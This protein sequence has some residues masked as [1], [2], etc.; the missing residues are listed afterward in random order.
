MKINRDRL[1]QIIKE[2]ISN[3]DP[4]EFPDPLPGSA[5]KSF[6][7]KGWDDTPDDGQVDDR[8]KDDMVSVELDASIPTLKLMPSQ[9]AIFLGKAL[10][11]SMVPKLSQGGQ[12]GGVISEDNHILDGHHRWAAT[13]LRTGGK[14]VIQGTK[15]NLPITQLIPVLR[16]T[17]DAYGNQ[18]KGE[19]EKGD[20]NLFSSQATNPAVIKQMIEQGKYMDPEFYNKEKLMAHVEKIGGI[21]AIVERVKLM[22]Q[23]G[24]KSYGGKGVARAPKRAQMPVLEPKKGQVKNTAKRLQKGTIDVA[25]PYGKLDKS[26]VA[27][28]GE[29]T[30]QRDARMKKVV[31]EKKKK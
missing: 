13:I 15:V 7:V 6:M 19:P 1:I 14:P 5:S 26:G 18:R 20:L 11:M 29:R 4:K 12:L 24:A 22:Q 2:E 25:P 3:F 31:S 8:K 23:L 17:G 21:D 27:H 10:G 9:N 30:K 28:T 16:A